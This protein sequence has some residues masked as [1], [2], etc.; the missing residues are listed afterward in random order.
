[1]SPQYSGVQYAVLLTEKIKYD[2]LHEQ[3]CSFQA[4][5]KMSSLIFVES[6]PGGMSLTQI[7]FKMEL[8]ASTNIWR[9]VKIQ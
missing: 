2:K 7:F 8:F 6:P 9:H 4:D 1:M 5:H 3:M